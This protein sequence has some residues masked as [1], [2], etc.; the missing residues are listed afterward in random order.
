MSSEQN[1]GEVCVS[2]TQLAPLGVCER[3]VVFDHCLGLRLTRERRLAMRRGVDAHAEFKSEGV[4]CAS[5]SEHRKA[6]RRGTLLARL[7]ESHAACR[8]SPAYSLWSR[9]KD[10]IPVPW[11]RP[12]RRRA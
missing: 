3:Q 5:N 7:A 6:P 4:N 2:A 11:S 12:S 10:R 1:K 9:L 8:R